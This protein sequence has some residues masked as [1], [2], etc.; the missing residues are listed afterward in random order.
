METLAEKPAF[1]RAFAKRRCLLPADGYF[2]WYPTEQ[3][4]QGRQAAASSRSSSARRTAGCWRWPGSTR[5][6][7]TRPATRTTPDRFLWTCTVITTDAEDAVGQI[8]DRMPLMVE[9]DR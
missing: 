4:D 2:E 9:P 8:H 7:A 6:G 3:H 1:K 5:S